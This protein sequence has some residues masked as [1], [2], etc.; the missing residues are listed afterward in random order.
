MSGNSYYS[1]KLHSLLGVI[2]LGLFLIEHALTNY[3]AFEGGK[4]G[5]AESVD[6]LHGLPLIFFL[7]LILIWLPIAFHGIYG[8][9]LAFTSDLNV[10]RYQYGRNWAFALQRIT[11]VVT[12]IFV[13]WHVWTTRVQVALGNT[14][15]DELGSHMHSIVSQPAYFVI[16]FIAVLAAV[17]HF[18]NGLWAF[19]VS[20]G[21][22]VGPRAQ[23]ISS[24]I[25]MG[26]FVIVS[27]LFLLSLFAFRSDEFAAAGAALGSISLG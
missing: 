2:P 24:N 5:F 12:F 23:R 10:T 11:G 27:V 1:R 26:I 14:S 3:S 13:I 15:Y 8:L 17:F 25:C 19:L 21:I 6:F 18:A 20:W 22:T 4:E 9:Y 16:Y 7:E